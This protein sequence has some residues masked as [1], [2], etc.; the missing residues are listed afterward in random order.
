MAEIRDT[1]DHISSTCE[2]L[3]L[4]YANAEAKEFPELCDYI[5]TVRLI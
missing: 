1:K 4:Y 3:G 2:A 5:K